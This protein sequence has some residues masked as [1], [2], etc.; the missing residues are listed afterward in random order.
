MS[1]LH[2]TGI[3]QNSVQQTHVFCTVVW[4]MPVRVCVAPFRHLRRPR[5]KGGEVFEACA[6]N[7]SFLHTNV[8]QTHVF[9]TA[10]WPMPVVCRKL[11][12]SARASNAMATNA[13]PGA[14]RE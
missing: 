14:V 8:Q 1:Y 12:F 7:I 9:C 13:S 5:E 3:G 2:T 6:E 11:M 10:F 4:P